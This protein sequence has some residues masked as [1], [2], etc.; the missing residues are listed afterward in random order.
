MWI[1]LFMLL[2]FA[3]LAAGGLWLLGRLRVELTALRAEGGPVAQAIE[4]SEQIEEAARKIAAAEHELDL[5]VTNP[6]LLTTIGQ[7]KFIQGVD[8]RQRALHLVAEARGL[9]AA[10]LAQPHDASRAL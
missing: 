5:F 6:Q 2:G 3:A 9:C 10:E 4:A 8:A 7:E 1:A